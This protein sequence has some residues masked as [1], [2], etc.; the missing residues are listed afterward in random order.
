MSE[1]R[2]VLDQVLFGEELS[3]Q[4]SRIIPNRRFSHVRRT[5]VGGQ[6]TLCLAL[7]RFL[8]FCHIASLAALLPELP[9]SHRTTAPLPLSW[10]ERRIED[11]IRRG[12]V[13][14]RDAQFRRTEEVDQSLRGLLFIGQRRPR[15]M[16]PR[17]VGQ[18]PDRRHPPTRGEVILLVHLA[19]IVRSTDGTGRL[20]RHRYPS[21]VT[22][23]SRSHLHRRLLDPVLRDGV[24][25]F[26]PRGRFLVSLHSPCRSVAICSPLPL[27]W[28][29]T[30]HVG[31]LSPMRRN[32]ST[33]Q[34]RRPA[35]RLNGGF[36]DP[37]AAPM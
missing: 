25:S 23:I 16:E 6:L 34:P 22:K 27:T 11:R 19:A 31:R 18:W 21:G 3:A 15:S 20:F 2:G 9:L 33:Y 14:T 29:P 30:P 26:G 13:S 7:C 17:S 12:A 8:D 35:P 36:S 28:Y 32:A 24:R 10:T 37:S 4:R 1:P 5:H